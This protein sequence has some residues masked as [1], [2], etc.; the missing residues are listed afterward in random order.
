MNNKTDFGFKEVLV[1]E[2]Q[3]LVGQVFSSVAH[4]YDLMNDIMSLGIHRL[5]KARMI[6]ELEPNKKL[7]DM[8]SGTGDIAKRYYLKSQSA[9]ITLSDINQDMLSM[10]RKKL[11]NENIFKGLNFVCANAEELPFSEMEYDYYTIAFGIRNVTH[12]NKALKEAY[13]V[14]KPGGKF[15]CLEFGKVNNECL[16]AF[17]DFYSFNI[18]PKIGNLVVGDED[19][20]RYFVESIKRFPSQETFVNMMNEAGFKLSKFKNLTAGV[21]ALY[22]GYRI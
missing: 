11:L 19:S 5:W 18:I 7:L 21:V 3:G 1:E 12:I 20:Y 13:R 8:A 22:V 14:L 6:D 4:K 10:G 16:S 9:E 17:Y 2:K 15:V